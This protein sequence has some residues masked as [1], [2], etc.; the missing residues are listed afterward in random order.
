MGTFKN[1]QPCQY[2]V[3]GIDEG[4]VTLNIRGRMDAS[5]AAPMI[6]ELNTAL[7]DRA[8]F[9]LT[10]DLTGVTYL[11]DFGAL[12]LLELKKLLEAGK[13]EFYIKNASD[14]VK[15][16]LDILNFD[17]LEMDTFFTKKR[18]PDIFIRLGDATLRYAADV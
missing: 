10:V 8:L 18:P 7:K 5:S 11:D 16:M 12:I 9:S 4:A 1:Q 15:E 3:S 14:K 17:S 13:D 2:E 6:R